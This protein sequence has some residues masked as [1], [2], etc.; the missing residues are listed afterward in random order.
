MKG[1]MRRA[2]AA[3]VV[4]AFTHGVGMDGGL[5]GWLAK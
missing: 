1:S 2:F 4:G 5:A 3:V